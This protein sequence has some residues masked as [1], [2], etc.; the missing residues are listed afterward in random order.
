MVAG[1]F[2]HDKDIPI[3]LGLLTQ[4][5]RISKPKTSSLIGRT[6]VG[7]FHAC[8]ARLLLT[9]GRRKDIL[10]SLFRFSLSL[11]SWNRGIALLVEK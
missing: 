10:N 7:T 3:A 6:G 8:S 4:N 1:R 9:A 2:W 11:E 5:S